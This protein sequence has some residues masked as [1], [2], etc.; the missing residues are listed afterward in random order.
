MAREEEESWLF[1]ELKTLETSSSPISTTLNLPRPLRLYLLALH[2]VV[3][4]LIIAFFAVNTT[5]NCPN[6]G[7]EQSWCMQ[8]V[9]FRVPRC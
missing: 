5:D 4:V 2:T 7:K 6:P 8:V 1:G 3:L 9:K